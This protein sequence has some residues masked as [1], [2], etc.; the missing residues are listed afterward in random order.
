MMETRGSSPRSE[1][2]SFVAACEKGIVF[3]PVLSDPKVT[4]NDKLE[5]I[6]GINTTGSKFTYSDWKK[7]KTISPL[8]QDSWNYILK[9]RREQ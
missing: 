4:I 1:L 3:D 7:A 5:L 9:R 2:L 8:P 6:N